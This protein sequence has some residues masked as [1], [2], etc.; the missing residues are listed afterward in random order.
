MNELRLTYDVDRG[1]ARAMAKAATLY[2]LLRPSFL[3]AIGIEVVLAIA[4][5][6]GGRNTW[7]LALLAAALVTVLLLFLQ[8]RTL[9]RALTARGFRPGTTLTVDWGPETFTVTAPQQSATHYRADVQHFAVHG[10]A[11][12]M[13]MRGSRLLLVLPAQ[14]VPPEVR[15]G[16]GARSH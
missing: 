8:T 2:R 5:A 6:A 4:F 1:T 14:L 15:P 7:A 3:G 13:R 10:E 9:T 12:L 11:A 16:L